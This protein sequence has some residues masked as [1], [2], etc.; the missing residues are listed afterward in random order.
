VENPAKRCPVAEVPRG[1]A[2][3]VNGAVEAAARA[4]SAWSKI[5]PRDR[6]RFLLRIA[7]TLETRSEELARTIALE[8]GTHCELR[9]RLKRSWRPIF[10]AISAGW[11]EN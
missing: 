2:A 11:L 8:T 10:S 1:D 6:G 5:A 3:D 7:D 4:F 9:R